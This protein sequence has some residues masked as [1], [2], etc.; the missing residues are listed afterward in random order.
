MSKLYNRYFDVPESRM[1]LLIKCTEV[2]KE[3]TLEDMKEKLGMHGLREID[4]EEFDKLTDL[5]TD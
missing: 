5:Y 2:A 4:K 3:Y 1:T